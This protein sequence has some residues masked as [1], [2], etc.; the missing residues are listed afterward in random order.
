MTAN[1]IRLT[2]RWLLANGTWH[3]PDGTP[4]ADWITEG[5]P[6]PED[7]DYPAFLSAAFH[8]DADDADQLP[9]LEA[10]AAAVAAIQGSTAQL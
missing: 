9:A 8:Y 3:A 5:N 10:Q 7:P 4:E 2:A 6:L 1:A